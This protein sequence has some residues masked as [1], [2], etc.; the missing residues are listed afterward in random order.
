MSNVLKHFAGQVKL[1]NAHP[2]IIVEVQRVLQEIN[3]YKGAIDG[4]PGANTLAAFAKFKQ[5]EYLE[6]P[7]ILGKSTAQALLEAIE[8]H[9]TPKDQDRAVLT[10]GNQALL[11]G[12]GTVWSQEE[13]Y[14]GS[15]FSWGEFT[16]DLQRVPNSIA[17][18][19]NIQKLAAYLDKARNYLGK[20]AITINSGYRPPAINRACGGVSNSRH[21]YGDAADIVVAGMHPH[22]VYAALNTWHGDNGGLGNS[23]YFTHLDLRGYR[24]RFKYG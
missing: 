23:A 8:N 15:N 17:V 10:G 2:D 21:I 13:V 5:Q 20:R 24:S 9:P 3:L 6:N 22:E 1:A 12:V 14:T 18:V 19:R 16:K 11:S 7:S 4:K